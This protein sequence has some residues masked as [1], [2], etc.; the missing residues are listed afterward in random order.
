MR[1]IGGRWSGWSLGRGAPP[2]AP[3]P[4][5]WSSVA[6]V[7]PRALHTDL[8]FALVHAVLYQPAPKRL[9]LFA[10]W[11]QPEG[12]RCQPI[13]SGAN[14]LGSKS[15]SKGN[16]M[17]AEAVFFIAFMIAIAPPSSGRNKKTPGQRNKREGIQFTDSSRPSASRSRQN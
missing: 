13:P 6:A 16:V 12:A 14:R 2:P 7:L 10:D 3:P 8:Q 5:F 11:R 4:R 9:I 15:G 1:R 17:D